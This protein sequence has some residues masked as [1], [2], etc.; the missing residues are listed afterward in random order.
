MTLRIKGLPSFHSRVNTAFRCNARLSTSAL[1]RRILVKDF[2]VT[3]DES[4]MRLDRFLRH[5]L[6][7][8]R[9][10]ATVNNPMI[11]KWLRKRQ[12][13]LLGVEQDFYQQQASFQEASASQ[14]E[15]VPPVACVAT[16]PISKATTV[17]LG[18]TR[19]ETGQVWRVR[20][21]W[22]VNDTNGT[23]STSASFSSSSDKDSFGDFAD[24]IQERPKSV[25]PLQDWVVY[26]DER[27]VVINK[28]AGIAVQGGTGVVQS[29]DDSLFGSV[30]GSTCV[31][32]FPNCTTHRINF[33]PI[34]A[35]LH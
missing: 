29:V 1:Q 21:V 11:S 13:K 23:S 3:P 18:S 19:T 12:V 34:A 9:D 7:G 8:D 16:K 25:L 27:I 26:K 6:A 31:S 24:Q 5:R 17:T 32:C 15:Q 20:T 10:L 35:L 28:P 14:I 30:H 33:A 2:V 22:E 4:G